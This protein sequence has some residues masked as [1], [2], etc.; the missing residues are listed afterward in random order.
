M[1]KKVIVIT[2]TSAGIGATTASILHEKGHIVYGL[3]RRLSTL[4]TFHSIQVDI[5]SELQVKK[6]IESII[7]KEGNIDVLINNA[8]MG[9]A[10]STE[11]TDLSEAKTLF[12]VNFFGSVS[13]MQ[14]VIPYMRTQGFGKII[15]IS[16]LAST[17][18]LPFQSFYSASK[19][20]L[21]SLSLALYNEVSPYGIDLCV[22]LPGDI[23]TSFTDARKM[24]RHVDNTYQKRI[25][26]SIAYMA[27]DEQNGMPPEVIGRYVLK[28]IKKKHM[29][30]VITLGLKYKA[31]LLLSRILPH[32]L[33]LAIIGSMYAFKKEK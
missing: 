11:Q 33:L 13:V 23:K 26:R 16:S 2:G 15:N 5:T 4:Q 12:D 30:K 3:S 20:A 29:P 19:A 18:P 7:Q 10:G 6:A 32:K 28:L 1:N 9:I 24:S 8:G 22:I 31:M 27:K 21:T 14:A 17:F 25:D